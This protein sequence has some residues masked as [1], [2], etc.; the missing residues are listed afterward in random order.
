MGLYILFIAFLQRVG[1]GA[2]AVMALLLI[3]S[4]GTPRRSAAI[5]TRRKLN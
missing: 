1:V 4:L 3:V 5:I 2:G